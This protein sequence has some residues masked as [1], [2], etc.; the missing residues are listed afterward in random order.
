MDDTHAQ[1]MLATQ[2]DREVGST[3]S[4]Y[5]GVPLK[6]VAQEVRALP[7]CVP[8]RFEAPLGALADGRNNLEEPKQNK[9]RE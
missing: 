6:A 1:E 3:V 9:E 8:Q 5:G 4:T 7:D 2:A